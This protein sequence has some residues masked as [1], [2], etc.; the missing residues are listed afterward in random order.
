MIASA[1]S[2]TYKAYRA[3]EIS[4]VVIGEGVG[5]GGG[6]IGNGNHAVLEHERRAVGCG[7]DRVLFPV[8][9]ENVIGSA[10]NC[11]GAV[12]KS[13]RHA[14]IAGCAVR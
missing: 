4:H 12:V 3:C 14:A 8:D 11:R 2:R 6:Y 9:C 1:R 5:V 7:V 13:D 10:G